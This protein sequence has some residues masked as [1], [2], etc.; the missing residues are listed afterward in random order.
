MAT[1][2]KK[3]I[4]YDDIIIACINRD[5]ISSR[6]AI[7]KALI[8]GGKTPRTLT[9]K[10]KGLVRLNI[11]SFEKGRSKSYILGKAMKVDD[12][13]IEALRLA[14]QARAVDKKAK[15]LHEKKME[16]KYKKQHKQAIQECDRLYGD[17]PLIVDFLD[18]RGHFLK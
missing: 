15:V 13:Y 6:K 12:K 11:I 18:A 9:S 5:G 17:N 1:Q 16:K 14:R 2:T 10:L 8:V 7:E 4:G 3:A